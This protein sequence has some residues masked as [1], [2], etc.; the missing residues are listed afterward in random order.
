VCRVQ[1]S[2]FLKQVVHVEP[3]G[4]KRL[5]GH[6]LNLVKQ[7]CG[8]T[9]WISIGISRHGRDIG[10]CV[11]ILIQNACGVSVNKGEEG[12]NVR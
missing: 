1:S 6:T 10:M 5:K 2:N 12:S 7:C 9:K 11:H 3:L 8:S 4:F